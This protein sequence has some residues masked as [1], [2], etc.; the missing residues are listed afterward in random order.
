[1][2]CVPQMGLLNMRGRRVQ[3]AGSETNEFRDKR[4]KT[5]IVLMNILFLKEKRRQR[6][7]GL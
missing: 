4:P 3:M 5:E 7:E 1:M 2:P 6:E